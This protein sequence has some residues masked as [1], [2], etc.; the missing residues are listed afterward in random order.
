MAILVYTKA[1][2]TTK[3]KK[4]KKGILGKIMEKLPGYHKEETDKNTPPAPAAAG[5]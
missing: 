3:K 5:H 4:G 2:G 1:M